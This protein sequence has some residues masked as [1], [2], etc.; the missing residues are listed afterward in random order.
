MAPR[1]HLTPPVPE[2][3]KDG[4][5]NHRPPV[6]KKW[7]RLFHAWQHR[8]AAARLKR[9]I[10]R[11][12]KARSEE[13]SAL[14]RQRRF[15]ERLFRRT[16]DSVQNPAPSGKAKAKQVPIPPAPKPR[17][18]QPS[19]T[20]LPISAPVPPPVS[21]LT[22]PTPPVPTP[23]PFS[24]PAAVKP[25]A[26]MEMYAAKAAQAQK[27]RDLA[28][29]LPVSQPPLVVPLPPAP[30]APV[31]AA[32][33]PKKS[34]F[35]PSRLLS[36]WSRTSLAKKL[37]KEREEEKAWQER[38]EVE[39]RFWQPY[40][41]VKPNLI[42]NQATVFFNWHEHFLVLI[43]S[44]II[45][46]LAISLVYVSLLVWQKERL[47]NNQSVV[48]NTRVLEAEIDK[49]ES[50]IKEV[51]AFNDKLGLVASLLD[52]HVYWTEMFAFLEN[53]TLKDIYYESFKGD[54]SGS[55]AIPAVSRSLDAVSLQL[56]VLKTNRGIEATYDLKPSGDDRAKVLFNL[57]LSLDPTIFL[58]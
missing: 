23:P 18:S 52:N 29:S 19:S 11:L 55:Y 56:E 40:A 53:N 22:V 7:L 20:A 26:S 46:C 31:P 8:A 35:Q 47:Q 27:E 10:V 44:V 15:Y 2:T 3:L 33:P 16:V 51:I 45:S 17:V 41:G 9:E 54:L 50:D 21:P 34:S 24:V 36:G 38:N 39:K 6:L 12:E 43:L 58:K 4:A 49:N 5:S 57:G 32:M 28:A 13:K 48:L 30:V 1:D 37:A 42:K 25:T 14:V